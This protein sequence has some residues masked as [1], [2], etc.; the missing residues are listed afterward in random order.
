M[1]VVICGASR[2]LWPKMGRKDEDAGDRAGGT[3]CFHSLSSV[4]LFGVYMM[5]YATDC[6]CLSHTQ[7]KEN[8]KTRKS[9]SKKKKK[10][11][12]DQVITKYYLTF[13]LIISFFLMLLLCCV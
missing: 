13:I 1:A 7:K 5:Q 2:E 6:D 10:N 9:S 3:R 11:D 4:F 8:I 12:D